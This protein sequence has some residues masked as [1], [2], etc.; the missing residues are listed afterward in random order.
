MTNYE[1]VPENSDIV[2]LDYTSCEPSC[3]GAIHFVIYSESVDINFRKALWESDTLYYE[4]YTKEELEELRLEVKEA[5]KYY[6]IELVDIE[7]DCPWD[8]E[9]K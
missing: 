9:S 3:C 8:W 2:Y 7:E 5:A 6:N 4:D 1:P